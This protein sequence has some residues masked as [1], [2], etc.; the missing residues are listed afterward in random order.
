MAEKQKEKCIEITSVEISVS[1]IGIKINVETH[2]PIDCIILA[3]GITNLL[4]EKGYFPKVL[5]MP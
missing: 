5:I 1:S 2:D 3:G 4:R